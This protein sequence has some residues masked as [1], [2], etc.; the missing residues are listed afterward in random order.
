MKTLHAFLVIVGVLVMSTGGGW[1]ADTSQAIDIGARYH[2]QHSVFTDLP[3]GDGDLSYGLGYEIH[4]ENGLIQL[5]CGYTPSLSDRDD[6]DFAITPEANLLFADGIFQGGVG[7]LT[8]YTQ[9]S[10][11]DD[12]MDLYWQGVLGINVPLGSFQIQVNAYY[13]F[14]DWD[15]LGEFEFGDIEYGAYLGYKF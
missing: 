14:E 15:K 10:G 4:D 9:G 1:A 12:W 6:L 2:F 8:T 13:V 3:F 5:I 7:A 11:T